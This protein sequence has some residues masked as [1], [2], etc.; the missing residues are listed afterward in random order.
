MGRGKERGARRAAQDAPADR[1]EERGS[2]PRLMEPGL[3]SFV[4][5]ATFALGALCVTGAGSSWLAF[6]AFY[7]V[8]MFTVLAFGFTVAHDAKVRSDTTSPLTE[9]AFRYIAAQCIYPHLFD[10]ETTANAVITTILAK[11]APGKV[12]RWTLEAWDAE[13]GAPGIAGLAGLIERA[14]QDTVLQWRV[15]GK[16]VGRQKGARDIERR[17]RRRW[18]ADAPP[19]P[20]CDSGRLRTKVL[21]EEVYGPETAE[22]KMLWANFRLEQEFDEGTTLQ[23]GMLTDEEE[24]W[25]E[26]WT[27]IGERRRSVGSPERQ[28]ARTEAERCA[29][30]RRDAARKAQREM[31]SL[32]EQQR[33]EKAALH[34]QQLREFAAVLRERGSRGEGAR[35]AVKA[36]G[37]SSSMLEADMERVRRALQRVREEEE[38]KEEEREK[39]EEEM[40]RYV[41]AATAQV[42]QMAAMSPPFTPV[43]EEATERGAER[44][45]EIRKDLF[46]AG[47]PGLR[48]DS[49][50]ESEGRWD[51]VQNSRDPPLRERERLELERATGDG[52]TSPLDVGVE[53]EGGGP[54]DRPP[55][56]AQIL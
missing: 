26:K 32:L 13:D 9:A 16:V 5:E 35:A 22:E 11:T 29:E 21:R 53:L 1:K 38:E 2:L 51:S 50:R 19:A 36:A 40:L 52:K 12:R 44:E 43:T 55:G 39:E 49:E 33:E 3:M 7:S 31:A 42:R 6:V 48:G 46:A 14:L 25:T 47:A 27:E 30:E 18:L 37:V 15:A 17:L 4:E 41:A 56:A 10:D 54:M 28:P 34:M 24:D 8:L 23:D 20:V 45:G